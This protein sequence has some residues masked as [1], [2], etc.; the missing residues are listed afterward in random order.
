MEDKLLLQLVK[1]SIEEE[2]YGKKIDVDF[3]L[4]EIPALKDNVAT[5]VT[6][7]KRGS[8]RGCIGS[9]VAHRLFLTDLVQNAK[10]AAFQDPRF[11]PLSK[12][13][14]ESGDLSIEISIL[15]KPKPLKYKDIIDLKQKIDIPNDGVILS[16]NGKRATFLPQ[17]W[18]Q[19][20]TFEIFFAHLCIKANLQ[21]D[22][23][24]NH[25]TI[26]VYNVKKIS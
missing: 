5:F 16:L 13:E 14:Y 8:L 19:L 25:P 2:L 1:D 21:Q 9:L 7:N 4:K 10:S 15:T 22:C 17:V 24:K 18:D 11:E 6:I 12:D 23:L 3:Y 26:E 20:P